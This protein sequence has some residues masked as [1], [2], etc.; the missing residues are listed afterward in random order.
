VVRDD[1]RRH[2]ETFFTVAALAFARLRL[3]FVVVAGAAQN[4]FN[5]VLEQCLDRCP[6]RLGFRCPLP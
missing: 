6:N 3:R 4:G 2:A 5:G 1:I